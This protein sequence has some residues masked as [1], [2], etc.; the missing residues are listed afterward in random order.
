MSQIGDYEE[1]VE[2]I[3]LFLPV[4]QSEPEESP[5]S[6]EQPEEVEVEK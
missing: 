5:I 3:P 6:V 1:T 2:I 4:P